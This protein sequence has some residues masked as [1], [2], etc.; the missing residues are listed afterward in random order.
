M[1]PSLPRASPP[2]PSCSSSC[3]R[4][5][6]TTAPS[7][8]WRRRRRSEPSSGSSR[9][10][11][12]TPPEREPSC[13]APC[14]RFHAP[15]MHAASV[16]EMGKPCECRV[17][18]SRPVSR[19]LS[20]VTISL[21]R[22]LP[23]GSSGVPGPSAGS[24]CGACFTLHRTGFGEPPCHHDAGGLLPHLFTLTSGVSGDIRSPEAVSFLCHFP[25]A[26]AAWDFPSVLPF[27]VRTFLES[28]MPARG[29][30]AC[31]HSVPRSRP[32]PQRA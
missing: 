27:G 16:P 24:V 1:G 15:V 20:W 3:W 19:I 11:A 12:P 18:L 17:F 23:G 21:G 26:F 22:R 9:L 25:S 14:W 6:A 31:G 2:R 28:A 13:A 4:S 30:P 7:P 32:R 5:A 10:P 29:H 8:P